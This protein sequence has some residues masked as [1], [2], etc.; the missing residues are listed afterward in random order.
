M[1]FRLQ[2]K[3]SLLLFPSK[4]LKNSTDGKDKLIEITD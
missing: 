3:V 1:L 4:I 2:K